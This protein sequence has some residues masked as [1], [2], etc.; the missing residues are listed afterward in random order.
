MGAAALSDE[1]IAA[2]KTAKVDPL[3]L[4]TSFEYTNNR[5][6]S[7]I[8]KV[9]GG[10]VRQFGSFGRGAK[11]GYFFKDQNYL[12]EFQFVGDQKNHNTG[13]DTGL[14]AGLMSKFA[15]KKPDPQPDVVDSADRK[16]RELCPKL[17]LYAVRRS[18]E[19]TYHVW[20]PREIYRDKPVDSPF[21]LYDNVEI[22][23]V[24]TDG[25]NVDDGWG[26]KVREYSWNH[27]DMVAYLNTNG[28][29]LKQTAGARKKRTTTTPAA[30]AWKR[31]NRTVA[32]KVVSASTGRAR[33]VHKTLYKN[34]AGE[35]RVKRVVNGA[36]RYVKP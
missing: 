30:P 5:F 8:D 20:L 31:A 11:V 36:V 25:N 13:K 21:M 17:G 23:K 10:R 7:G 32:V 35:L 14:F 2:L 34:R 18:D 16:M 12:G 24:Y 29:F 22:E 33:T 15:P 9:M 19:S 3:E 1:L 6:I 26:N 28:F 4:S 27:P